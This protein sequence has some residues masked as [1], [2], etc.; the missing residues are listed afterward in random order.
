M[1]DS[2]WLVI[3]QW[4]EGT[5]RRVSLDPIARKAF[6]GTDDRGEPVRLVIEFPLEDIPTR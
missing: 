2:T 5:E 4:F 1:A 3:P 6:I